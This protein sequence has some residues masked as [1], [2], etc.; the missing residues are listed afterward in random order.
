MIVDDTKWTSTPGECIGANFASGSIGAG[1]VREINGNYFD[2]TLGNGGSGGS[3]TD[4]TMALNFINGFYCLDSSGGQMAAFDDNL[5]VNDGSINSILFQ[6]NTSAAHP[7]FAHLHSNAGSITNGH[8]FGLT[9]QF[10]QTLDGWFIEPGDTD[11][12]GDY[13]NVNSPGSTRIW[14]LS[15]NI[16]RLN[17]NDV[18]GGMFASAQG[19]SLAN[20]LVTNNTYYSTADSEESGSCSYGET[21]AGHADMFDGIYNNLVVGTGAGYVFIRRVNRTVSD[22][23]SAVNIHHNGKYQLS[24]GSLGFPGYEDKGD[25]GTFAAMFS[26]GTPGANDV[27]ANPSFVDDTRGITTWAIARG[28]SVSGTYNGRVTDAYAAIYAD[29]RNRIPDLVSWCRAGFAPTSTAFQG[30]GSGGVDIGAM[31]VVPTTANKP[32]N[33]LLMFR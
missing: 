30:T 10:D 8:M 25:T 21:Y 17:K 28:Y 23:C 22:G 6:A 18:H 11:A 32:G 13:F 12:T 7:N 3:W 15:H 26:S 2:K 14:T 1:G 9:V 24:N 16:A 20:V 4:V 31:T 27:T 29:P 33:M 5:L 19:S